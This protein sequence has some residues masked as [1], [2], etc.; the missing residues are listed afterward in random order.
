ML[1][2]ARSRVLRPSLWPCWFRHLSHADSPLSF[3]LLINDVGQYKR[4]FGCFRGVLP[5]HY[6]WFLLP[7]FNGVQAALLSFFMYLC[8]KWFYIVVCFPEFVCFWCK[9]AWT[10]YFWC[11]IWLWATCVC[12]HKYH[13]FSLSTMISCHKKRWWHQVWIWLIVANDIVIL[14]LVVI[15]IT[16]VL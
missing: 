3:F 16:S 2:R 5:Y 14:Y 9:F 4:L 15:F 11:S 10:V 13:G 7:A 8:S 1:P 12:F 6:T